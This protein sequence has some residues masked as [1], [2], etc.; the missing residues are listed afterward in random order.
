MNDGSCQLCGSRRPGPSTVDCSVLESRD[1]QTPEPESTS[2]TPLTKID[3]TAKR[4][5]Q[6]GADS[7][8]SNKPICAGRGGRQRGRRRGSSAAD[9]AQ[10]GKGAGY[11]DERYTKYVNKR[12]EG[13]RIEQQN[14]RTSQWARRGAARRRAEGCDRRRSCTHGTL[15]VLVRL[16]LGAAAQID[17]ELTQTRQNSLTHSQG[18]R[19]V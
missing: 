2:V 13:G 4:P 9:M 14:E 1:A 3:E 16:G 7:N 11:W 10:Y 19:N 6:T 12:E 18:Q 5:R 8:K 15:R 17:P